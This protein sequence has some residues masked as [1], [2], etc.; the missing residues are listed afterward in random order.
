[1]VVEPVAEEDRR[2]KVQGDKTK[3]KGKGRR[4]TPCSCQ[5]LRCV[6]VCVCVCACMRV[7]GIVCSVCTK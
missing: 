2:G 6:C 1:M 3:G 7:C 4:V 5:Q